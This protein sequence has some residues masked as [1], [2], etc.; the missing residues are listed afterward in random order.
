MITIMQ[1]YIYK[2]VY[3]R[4]MLYQN[5]IHVH[6]VESVYIRAMLYQNM[7]HVHEVEYKNG[8]NYVIALTT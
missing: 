8:G 5:M 3:I 7:I 6:E 1:V 4:A 2:S